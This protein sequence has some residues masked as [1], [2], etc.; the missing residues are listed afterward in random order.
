MTP[1]VPQVDADTVAL[2]S[3]FGVIPSGIFTVS[4]SFGHRTFSI[5]RQAE[6]AEFAPGKRVVYLK[7]TGDDG[8]EQWKAFGFVSDQTV[9]WPITVWQKHR[10]TDM[11]AYGELLTHMICGGFRRFTGPD[12]QPHRYEILLS[13]RCFRC[14]RRLTDPDSIQLGIGPECRKKGVR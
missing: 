12:G 13:R 5:E 3:T 2:T 4:S 1:P 14:D 6:G 11:D 10:G 9:R 8:G 7:T